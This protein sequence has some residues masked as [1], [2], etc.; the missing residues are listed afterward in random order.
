MG[1]DDAA[2][3]VVDLQR[4]FCHPSGSLARSGLDCRAAARVV[5]PAIRLV[6][7]A[8]AA[9]RPVVFTR[10][11]LRP[12]WGDAGLLAEISP[13]L[14]RVNGLVRGTPDV[15]LMPGLDP[16]PT[17]H[18]VDKQRYSAFWDTHLRERLSR[19]A[20]ETVVV[21]GVTTNVCVAATARDAFAFDLRVV[22]VADA[23]ADVDD[24]L[25][26]GALRSIAYAVGA[27]AQTDAV[28]AQLQRV[29]ADAATRHERKPDE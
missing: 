13:A 16:K 4:A 8:R 15:D 14:R 12:D 3:I 7:A 19:H 20:I 17:D 11:V 21:C 28:L 6:E 24:E 26:A 29:A 1:L 18:V 10:Y 2:L 9:G 27:V 22:V 25:H 5:A 23:T